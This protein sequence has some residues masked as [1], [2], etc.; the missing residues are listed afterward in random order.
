[1]NLEY[2][3]HPENVGNPPEACSLDR[4]TAQLVSA[5]NE[6]RFHDLVQ[7]LDAI[8][9]EGDPGTFRFTFV[10]QRAED[11]LGY[12]V[13]RW[14]T[15]PDLWPNMIHPEDRQRVLSFCMAATQ[16]GQDH[17]FEYRAI[18]A[19]GRVVWLH[20][21]VYMV[22]DESGRAC[23]VRGLMIDITERKQIEA[24]LQQQAE[25]ERLMGLIAQR[26]RQSLDLEEIL[27]TTV[28]EVR[29]FLQ[30]ERVLIFRL[31][32][33]GNGVVA[34]ESAS[35]DWAGMLGTTISTGH[36]VDLEPAANPHGQLQVID[37]IE[38]ADL[39]PAY[40][41]LLA[42]YQVR[43]KVGL[44][45]YQGNQVWGRLVVHHCA[46]PRLWQTWEV[47]FLKQ[48]ATQVAI[49]IQ[50]SD[51]YQQ[52]AAANRQLRQ[53]AA[54]DSLTQLAN[55]RR[56]DEYLE[57]TWQQAVRE[58]APLSLILGDID[59]FKTYNDTY[60]HQAGDECLQQIAQAMD[61]AV[62]R[63]ADLVARYGGEEFA[64][65]LPQTTDEGAIHVAEMIQTEVQTLQLSHR[66]PAVNPTPPT[67]SFG[68]ATLTPSR[69]GSP[70]ALIAAADQ[71]L[72]QAKADGR[73]CVRLAS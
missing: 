69:E 6:R 17:D 49:A 58:K 72:Y 19:D 30:A 48:L 54:S 36:L 55:R 56:F 16:A 63:P 50:Q 52:L 59:C 7:T 29:Q 21:R 61:R 73:N 27:K 66:H 20:D 1:M 18:A 35:P 22:R 68:V 31:T 42:Q 13:E 62:K 34:V 70:D 8:V 39:H 47:E 38:T 45:L 44:P 11:I 67:L 5:A 53:L 4:Q 24:A 25:R 37:D 12:P 46:G 3:L 33:G 41:E 2:P 43:A 57:Q 9:W 28:A 60:G 15:E 10:S 40:R 71:A 23:Q 51:L 32:E 26:I 64:V 65:I 14:L